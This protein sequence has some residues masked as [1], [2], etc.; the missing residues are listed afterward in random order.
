MPH[1]IFE[2]GEKQGEIHYGYIDG[3]G[4]YAQCFHKFPEK[5]NGKMEIGGKTCLQQICKTLNLD[6]EKVRPIDK[7]PNVGSLEWEAIQRA[8]GIILNP[9]GLGVLKRI[10]P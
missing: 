10:N 8:L 7:G 3:G 4:W 1:A 9:Q 6:Y 2:I 5:I